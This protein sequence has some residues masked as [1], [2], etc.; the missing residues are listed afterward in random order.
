MS[1]VESPR[2]G[3]SAPSGIGNKSDATAGNA[4]GVRSKG[5]GGLM[6]QAIAWVVAERREANP[7]ANIGSANRAA[8]SV[9]SDSL[10][11]ASVAARRRAAKWSELRSA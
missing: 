9:G 11:T 8:T 10:A 3:G 1:G 6:A 7:P 5:V 4:G 2:E